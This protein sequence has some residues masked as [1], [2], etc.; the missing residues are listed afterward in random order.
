MLKGKIANLWNIPASLI[1][2]VLFFIG[3]GGKSGPAVNVRI[4]WR[5]THPLQGQLIQSLK[6]T[7]I[8]NQYPLSVDFK[9]FDDAMNLNEAARTGQLDVVLTDAHSAVKLLSL[10]DNWTIIGR[11]SYDRIPLYVPRESSI[12]AISDLKRKRIAGVIPGTVLQ[13]EAF[14]ALQTAGLDPG[15]DVKYVDRPVKDWNRVH[16]QI[17]TDPAAAELEAE[18]KIRNLYVGKG[19]S[20]ILIANSFIETHSQVVPALLEAF[21]DANLYVAKNPEKAAEWFQEEAGLQ[22]SPKAL[23][24][25]ASLEPNYRAWMKGHV[26]MNLSELDL[27]ALRAA[28]DFIKEQNPVEKGVDMQA[29]VDLHYLREAEKSWWGRRDIEPKIV[30]GESAP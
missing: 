4:G 17:S 11:V 27:E 2:V 19:V 8:L 1:I 6:K 26:S 15:R 5:S 13:R 18:G 3:C 7:D 12:K 20:I 25:C 23:R 21:L 10:D 30:G 9:G 28:A 29:H 24:I 14:K 22:L 16:A